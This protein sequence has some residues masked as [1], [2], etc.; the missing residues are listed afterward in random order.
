MRQCDGCRE[1]NHITREKRKLH[2]RAALRDAV[3][4]GGHAACNLRRGAGF[5]GRV[6]YEVGIV[7]ERLMGAQ[8]VIVA[9]DDGDIGRPSAHGQL[10]AERRG[11]EG[12]RK[13]PT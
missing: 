10:V 5:A 2:A 3:A 9:R 8:H 12:V 4:H 6:L 7:L 13:V 11:G 1:R